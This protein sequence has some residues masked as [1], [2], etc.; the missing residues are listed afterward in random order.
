M[1]LQGNYD[2]SQQKRNSSTESGVDV[3]GDQLSSS[4]SSEHG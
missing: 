1:L 2:V 3:Q 4:S